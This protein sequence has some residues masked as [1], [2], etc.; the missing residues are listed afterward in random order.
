MIYISFNCASSFWIQSTSIKSKK[1]E[2]IGNNVI[3]CI[4][5]EEVKITA[6]KCYKIGWREK[7]FARQKENLLLL[8]N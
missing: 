2:K 5:N 1:Y 4:Y 7:K 8:L 3:Q 6:K